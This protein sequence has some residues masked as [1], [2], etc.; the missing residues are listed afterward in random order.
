MTINRLLI[1]LGTL[2]FISNNCAP[3]PVNNQGVEG[4]RMEKGTSNCD[5]PKW[6]RDGTNNGIE[7]STAF[8][9]GTGSSGDEMTSVNLAD[10]A[11]RRRAAEQVRSSIGGKL[12]KIVDEAINRELGSGIQYADQKQRIQNLL[13]TNLDNFDCSQCQVVKTES[14]KENY[15]HQTWSRVSI[16]IDTY[17]QSIEKQTSEAVLEDI[18]NNLGSDF[19]N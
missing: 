8:G 16:N 2:I 6:Y 5:S 3:P 13:Q 15:M 14:C 1:L 9:T 19:S 4:Y 11:A 17:E 12:E 10:A 7:G 18:R